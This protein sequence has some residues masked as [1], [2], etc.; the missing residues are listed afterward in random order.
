MIIWDRSIVEPFRNADIGLHLPPEGFD[1]RFD[2]DSIKTTEVER[3]LRGFEGSELSIQLTKHLVGSVAEGST[4]KIC[5]C[6]LAPAQ[7]LTSF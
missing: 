4:F 7:A 5:K 1:D 6:S 2:K 3:Q